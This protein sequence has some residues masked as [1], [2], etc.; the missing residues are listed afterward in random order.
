MSRD[1]SGSVA[2]TPTKQGGRGR[3]QLQL[4]QTPKQRQAKHRAKI[5]QEVTP[6]GP[7]TKQ[8]NSDKFWTPADARTQV[9]GDAFWTP[10]GARTADREST[11]AAPSTRIEVSSFAALV[12]QVEPEDGETAS[13][14]DTKYCLDASFAKASKLTWRVIID[15]LGGAIS[16]FMKEEQEGT[17][18]QEATQLL[19]IVVQCM[20]SFIEECGFVKDATFLEETFVEGFEKLAAMLQTRQD[21]DERSAKPI[22]II[23]VLQDLSV[24]VESEIGDC[25]EDGETEAGTYKNHTK[26]CQDA[27]LAK[28]AKP[29]Q[30]AVDAQVHEDDQDPID[31]GEPM[32]VEPKGCVFAELLHAWEEATEQLENGIIGLGASEVAEEVESESPPFAVSPVRK[33]GK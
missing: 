19:E 21:S 26:Y 6:G 27:S 17:A 12:E 11:S 30:D 20:S 33:R 7:H 28:D 3:P 2:A 8:D 10:A 15:V 16:A 31:F 4:V 5:H 32:D 14:S 9:D 22:R 1:A 23:E 25:G 24:I 13:E 18:M 29:Y